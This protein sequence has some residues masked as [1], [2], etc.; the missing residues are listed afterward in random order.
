MNFFLMNANLKNGFFFIAMGLLSLIIGIKWKKP[1][2]TGGAVHKYS[3]IVFGV[4]CVLVGVL[5]LFNAI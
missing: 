4:F 2:Y 3:S 1:T 5:F